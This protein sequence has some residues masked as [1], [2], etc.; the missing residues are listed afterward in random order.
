[1]ASIHGKL[2]ELD[3]WV[4]N[5][6][7][8]CIWHNWKKPERKRKN[9]IRLGVDHDHA[10]QWSRTRMGGWAVAQ[11]PI[12]IT[13]V[14]LERLRKRGYEAMLAYYEKI[15][16][17]LNEPLYTYVQWCERLSD[18]LLAYRRSTRLPAG[19]YSFLYL[20]NLIRKCPRIN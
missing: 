6:L 12:L 16:T 10:Y 11:S 4:R 19:L 2:K 13:T 14:T 7:R 1:M 9:L 3:G 8:Y 5:R 20:L 15:A 17:H 18:R